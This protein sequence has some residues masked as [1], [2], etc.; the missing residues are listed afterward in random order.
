MKDTDSVYLENTKS[1]PPSMNLVRAV[2]LL[3]HGGSALDIGCGSGRDSQFL[4]EKGFVVTAIDKSTAAEPHLAGMGGVNFVQ[5]DVRQFQLRSYDIVNAMYS[6][7]FLPR[8]DFF[9][10]VPKVLKSIKPDGFF[11]GNI[12]GER[13]EWNDGRATMT[14]CTK[15]E[16]MALFE[17]FTLINFQDNERDGKL[18]NGDPKYWHDFLIVAQKHQ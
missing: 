8:A 7:S 12:F 2:E 10:T 3:G 11:A 6:L 17:D 15:E 13:D 18:A 9:T 1:M 5:A 14:F 4:A 16:V